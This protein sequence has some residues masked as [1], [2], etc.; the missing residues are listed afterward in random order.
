MK[1]VLF[2][3]LFLISILLVSAARALA[4]PGDVLLSTAYPSVVSDKGKLVTFILT[5]TNR[6][7]DFQEVELQAD[8]PADWN[9]AFKSFGQVVKRA[10]VEPVKSQTV[11]F[12]VKAPDTARNQ[13][14]N[15]NLRAL[16]KDG[17]ATS[18][19]RV[20]VSLQERTG[21][22]GLKL[23][24]Q[25]PELRG[26]ANSTTTFRVTMTNDADTDRS[27]NF[28]ATAPKDWE[29]T[30][31]PAFESRQ[32]AVMSVRGGATQDIDVDIRVPAK[33]EA[34]AYAVVA[35]VTADKDRAEIPL[36]VVV[37]GNNRVTLNTQ[38]GALSARASVGADT[39]LTLVIKNS[40]SAPLQD[41]TFNSFKPDGWEVTFAPE[42]VD[43]LSV[44]QSLEVN[45]TI[46]PGAKA[47]AGD[48]IVTLNVNASQTSDSKDIR[49]T[50][51]TPT[52]WGI[53]AVIAIA[54]VIGGLGWV[55]TK[56][57]RR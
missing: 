25:F 57:S 34:G 48:Y 30:F 37:T 21:A 27:V 42:R 41:V 45:A 39:K 5:L 26:T 50:V 32:V 8:G 3:S 7:N 47:L 16:G 17:K 6:T 43:A 54:L 46:K 18:E 23:V 24:T 14:Y 11:D 13:D 10:M 2:F 15:F 35:R 12:Q 9:P 20:T 51:E 19:L 22:T 56:Y 44:D 1:R 52:T 31:K 38:S 40:G 33:T 29:V 28:S 49:V 53:A 4:A 55:F 36:K